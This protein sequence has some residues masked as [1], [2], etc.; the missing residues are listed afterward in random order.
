MSAGSTMRQRSLIMPIWRFII[1][2]SAADARAS[3]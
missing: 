3:V 2:N 1:A